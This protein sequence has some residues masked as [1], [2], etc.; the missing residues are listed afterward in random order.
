[1]TPE[2]RY[3]ARIEVDAETGCWNWTGSDKSKAGY[4]RFFV[5]GKRVLVHRWAYEYFVG[6]IPE[7]WTVHHKCVNTSCSNPDHL[8]AL[9]Q[10]KNLLESE[11]AQASV[12][13]RA[14]HCVN[15]HEFTSRNTYVD[16]KSGRR[17][18]RECR[19][20]RMRRYNA[21]KKLERAK[22]KSA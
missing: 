18:C 1:M 20:A 5:E 16:P 6:P 14:T 2:Q 12:L 4:C 21:R 22:L 19:N 10:L 9:S 13:A 17:T 15:G 7:G 3:N 11:T 8:E